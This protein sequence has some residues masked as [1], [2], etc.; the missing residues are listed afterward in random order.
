MS[1]NSGE[2]GDF[3]RRYMLR[4]KDRTPVKDVTGEPLYFSR[5]GQAKTYRDSVSEDLTVSIG[6]DHRKW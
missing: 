1:M 4:D 6:P 5:K 3:K 2:K